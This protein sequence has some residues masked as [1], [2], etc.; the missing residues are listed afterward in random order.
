MKTIFDLESELNVIRSF[1]PEAFGV[2]YQSESNPSNKHYVILRNR[3]ELLN[4]KSFHKDFDFKFIEL[5][6]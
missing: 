4:L 3:Q 6:I 2:F 1:N 5:A